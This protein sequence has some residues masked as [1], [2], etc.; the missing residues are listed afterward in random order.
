MYCRE[1]LRKLEIFGGALIRPAFT[2]FQSLSKNFTDRQIDFTTLMFG[3]AILASYLFYDIN[4][5]KTIELPNE[6]N[7][8]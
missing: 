3:E 1:Q 7:W 5:N 4:T 6:N 2:E 8:V